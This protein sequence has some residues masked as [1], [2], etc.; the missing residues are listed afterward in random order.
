M[1]HSARPPG[2]L[3]ILVIAGLSVVAVGISIIQGPAAI[4]TIAQ[5]AG[6]WIAGL[7]LVLVALT[8]IKR[9]AR[10]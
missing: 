2:W 7:A 8:Y 9:P 10:S 3:I 6:R 1:K 5:Q 4:S